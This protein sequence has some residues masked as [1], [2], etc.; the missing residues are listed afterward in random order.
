MRALLAL[1]LLQHAARVA[2]AVST[3]GSGSYGSYVSYSHECRHESM[4]DIMANQSLTPID[5]FKR[6]NQYCPMLGDVRPECDTHHAFHSFYSTFT[7]AQDKRPQMQWTVM[8]IA[9]S[10][11]AACCPARGVGYAHR[12]DHP[13][14]REATGT[15][16]VRAQHHVV[17]FCDAR[18]CPGRCPLRCA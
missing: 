12:N 3:G 8:C 11:C 7:E 16:R 15:C 1:F 17:G 2:G 4:A 9:S 5:M 6:C 18:C 14:S 10:A 13:H